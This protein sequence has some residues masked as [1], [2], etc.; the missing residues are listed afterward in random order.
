MERSYRNTARLIVK[1]VHKHSATHGKRA[2]S[3]KA[4]KKSADHDALEIFG[5]RNGEVENSS[6]ESGNDER[7]S[8][9]LD[10]R[11]WSP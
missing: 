4:C 6:P 1:Q 2:S 11:K 3:K 9:P 8:A 7:Q 10:F 5:N